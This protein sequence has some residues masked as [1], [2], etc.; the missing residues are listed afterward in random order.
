MDEVKKE[1]TVAHPM[2]EVLGIE[3]ST[4]VVEFTEVLPA[5]PVAA[6]MYDEKDDEIE[7]KIEEIYAF[8]MSKVATVAD[9]I[10]IVEGKYRARL[11]EVTANMLSIALGAVQ[12]KR[13][14]KQHKDRLA[15]ADSGGNP[16]SVTNNNVIVTRNEL[17]DMLAKNRHK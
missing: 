11:G 14:L 7:G 8:A 10:D 17:L 1:K 15:V 13:E 6:P 16:R 4:T 9:Q 3:D 5:V 12:Q 2:E